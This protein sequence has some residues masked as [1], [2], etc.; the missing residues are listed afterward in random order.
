MALQP[1]FI[2]GV[3][4]IECLH[5]KGLFWTPLWMVWHYVWKKMQ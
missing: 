4:A 5:P 1:L 2:G 3:E